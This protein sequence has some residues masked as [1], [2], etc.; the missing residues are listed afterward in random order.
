MLPHGNLPHG[1][2]AVG[3]L[4]IYIL[5]VFGACICSEMFG[6]PCTQA[7]R[8]ASQTPTP[9]LT[10]NNEPLTRIKY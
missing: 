9:P 7:P 2:I 4:L 1:N 5:G 8:P 10:Q 3:D 6:S